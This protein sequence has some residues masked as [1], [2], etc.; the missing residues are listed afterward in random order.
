M[1]IKTMIE[2]SV[3]AVL[4]AIGARMMVP[5]PIVPFTL[6]TLFCLLAGL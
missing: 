1:K 3:F 5:V 6:L 4:T 2:I